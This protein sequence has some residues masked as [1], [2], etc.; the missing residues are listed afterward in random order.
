MAS[1]QGLES[2][3]CTLCKA[4]PGCPGSSMPVSGCVL[5]QKKD[6]PSPAG[7]G[8]TPCRGGVAGGAGGAAVAIAELL[9]IVG[10][11]AAL[12]FLQQADYSAAG[13]SASRNQR[14]LVRLP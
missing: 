8:C 11:A 10:S 4:A 3:T 12:E 6:C 2:S 5:R 7:S 1:I 9:G 14:C 13:M